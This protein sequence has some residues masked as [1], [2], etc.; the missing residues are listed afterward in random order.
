MNW[1][2]FACYFCDQVNVRQKLRRFE[3]GHLQALLLSSSRGSI[4]LIRHRNVG[5]NL[6]VFVKQRILKSKKPQ[7]DSSFATTL[8]YLFICTS[9][10]PF[11]SFFFEVDVSQ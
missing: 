2:S 5:E 4:S 3:E 1:N 11:F 10:K 9:F 8:P 6:R 7:P